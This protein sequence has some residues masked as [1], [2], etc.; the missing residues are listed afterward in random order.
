MKSDLSRELV[1]RR[2]RR[3]SGCLCW[4]LLCWLLPR[5]DLVWEC[6]QLLDQRMYF[7]YSI[8][9]LADHLDQHACCWDPV[10]PGKMSWLVLHLLFFDSFWKTYKLTALD[11]TTFLRK[12]GFAQYHMMISFQKF[13]QKDRTRN[14]LSISGFQTYYH[15]GSDQIRICH[16]LFSQSPH[17]QEHSSHLRLLLRRQHYWLWG[18][19]CRSQRFHS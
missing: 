9:I 18:G 12:F 14:F 6:W 13:V 5:Q 3:C 11:L 17:L 2:G 15:L 16:F 1:Q 19:S 4:R 8:I 7:A 10:S